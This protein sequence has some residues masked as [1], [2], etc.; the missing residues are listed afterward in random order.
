MSLSPVWYL[1]DD[2]EWLT[3]AAG[4]YEAG[5]CLIQ[6][7]IM[8]L[9]IQMENLLME[10]RTAERTKVDTTPLAVRYIEAMHQKQSLQ[11]KKGRLK[12]M[13]GI[14]T[15]SYENRKQKEGDILPL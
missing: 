10:V 1:C 3:H 13:D 6:L 2:P 14:L 8:S 4:L 9:E 5:E 11:T 7:R 12:F 15:K